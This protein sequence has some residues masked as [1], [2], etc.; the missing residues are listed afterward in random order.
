[1]KL[2]VNNLR[3]KLIILIGLFSPLLFACDQSK[4]IEHKQVFVGMNGPINPGIFF[5]ENKGQ[6][7]NSWLQRALTQ[8]EAAS[9]FSEI[10]FNSQML[11][12]IAV[13]ER[14]S[15]SGKVEVTGIKQLETEKSS[16]IDITALVGIVDKKCRNQS[17][18]S[19]PFTLV[20]LKK[21]SNLSSDRGFDIGNFSDGCVAEKAGKTTNP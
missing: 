17:L 3:C 4:T 18:K 15:A 13:C 12:A 1:M 8:N 5:F 14:N 11:L 9:L 20:I 16:A 21:T 10:D 6:I 19:Y 2:L 7:E